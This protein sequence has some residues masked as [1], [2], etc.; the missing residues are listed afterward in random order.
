MEE[1]VHYSELFDIY[2]RVLTD[3]QINTFRDYFFENLTLEEIAENNGISKNAVSKSLMNIKK[4]LD[5]KESE[6]HILEY[7]K[8]LK[9]EFEGEKEILI[10]LEKYDNIILD[11]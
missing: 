3:K 9:K 7:M 2:K 1:L 11:N 5:S 10:R 4:I 6:L 8:K